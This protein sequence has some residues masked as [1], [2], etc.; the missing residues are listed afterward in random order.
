MFPAFLLVMAA[1][2]VVP[3]FPSDLASSQPVDTQRP[4]YLSADTAS[5]QSAAP[6]I[7][8]A[9]SQVVEMTVDH[10]KAMGLQVAPAGS[11]AYLISP[12]AADGAANAS[13]YVEA[14]TSAL[15]SATVRLFVG[16][17]NSSLP[18]A[19]GSE[20]D[21]GGDGDSAWR[22]AYEVQR[23]VVSG[24]KDILGY[25]SYDRGEVQEPAPPTGLQGV[26]AQDP[27]VETYPL[28]DSNPSEATLLQEPGGPV[29]LSAALANAIHDYFDPTVHTPGRVA[30]FD[31]RQPPSWQ[32]VTPKVVSRS[33]DPV[34]VAL[35]FD[36]GASSEP[37]PAIL[38][39]LTDAG[40]P[41]TIFLTGDFVEKNQDLVVQMARD[42]FEFG[43]HS[44]THP[45]MTTVSS[46]E[47]IDQLNGVEKKVMALTGKSTRPW[48]RPPF[49]A[50]NDRVVQVAADQGYY[51]VLW[52]QDSADWRNDI[53]AATV[54]ARILRYA[55]SGSII[56]EHLGSP[57]SAQVLPEVLRVL[58]SRG[59][60]FGTL[61]EVMGTR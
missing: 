57:Q 34:R 12:A 2:V 59:V 16:L 21:F 6:E 42:G 49:G 10:L 44:S 35:T 15:P 31:W 11:G 52:T 26:G 29:V 43:N 40:V 24:L 18:A 13:G 61:S 54:E 19:S 45:D 22:L 27:W 53:D 20:T 38:K 36:G 51:S 60:T 1:L 41:A 47:E 28:F 46:Q 4:I 56:I 32:P 55:T 3:F 50:Y 30:E 14:S 9:N 23:N 33:N 37:T 48:F 17:N 5:T 7:A 58:K 39:A 8:T 25:D